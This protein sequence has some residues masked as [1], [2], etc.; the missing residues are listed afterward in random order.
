MDNESLEFA[1]KFDKYV[2]C[3]LRSEDRLE[4]ER[5]D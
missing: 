5:L 2:D 1:P 3:A 4:S